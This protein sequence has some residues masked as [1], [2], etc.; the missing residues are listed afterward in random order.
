MV[1]FESDYTNGACKEIMERLA[2]TNDDR[3]TGYMHDDYCE[4]AR[5]KIAEACGD[6]DAFVYFA[7]GG[8]QANALVTGSVLKDYQGVM[9]AKTGHI[10]LHEGGAIEFTGH[11]V[12]ELG[13]KDGKVQAEELENY[14][15]VFYADEN[16]DK[17][18]FPGM[19]YISHPTEYGTLYTKT[20]LAKLSEICHQYGMKLYLDGARLGY[21]LAALNTDVTLKDIYRLCDIFYI[22]GTK[23]GAFCGEA[24][25]FARGCEPEHF[26]TVAKQRGALI[27]KGRLVG[28]QFDTLFTD[29]LYERIGRHAID[30]AMRI[31]DLFVSRGYRMYL[32]S[33]TNQQ[34]VILD[35]KKMEELKSK[36]GFAFWEKYD[37]EHTVVRFASSWSTTEEDMA[38][39]ES[40]V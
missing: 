23:V 4:S 18:V 25:V 14:L 2:E 19:L 10:S 37:E 9:A 40:I 26:E 32:D 36:V 38:Y 8:T 31:R 34:F 1:T 5:K 27:A 22:G 12:I 30:M 13:H 3:Q 28:V 39:L 35:N 16:L 20:E 15:K 29:G 33:P 17:M 11:K 21:G 6:P 7:V 24:I